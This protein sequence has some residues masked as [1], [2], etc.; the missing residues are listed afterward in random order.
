MPFLGVYADRL[1]PQGLRLAAR[2]GNRDDGLPHTGF[3]FE[4]HRE[5]SP[6]LPALLLLRPMPARHRSA[7]VPTML[8]SEKPKHRAFG[9]RDVYLNWSTLVTLTR[10]TTFIL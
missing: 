3:H 6:K 8:F 9:L 5:Q 2:Q 4:V 7:R 1:I 10:A